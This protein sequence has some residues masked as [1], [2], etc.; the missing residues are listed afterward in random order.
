LVS[1]RLLTRLAD[2]D[3]LSTSAIHQGVRHIDFS[4][5]INVEKGDGPEV[6]S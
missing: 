3:I 6:S 4:L 5:K 2:I 1:G